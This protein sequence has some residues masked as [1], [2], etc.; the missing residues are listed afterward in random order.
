MKIQKLALLMLSVLTLVSAL[1][2]SGCAEEREPA[3]P[4]TI[5]DGLGRTIS[6]PYRPERL[7]CLTPSSAEIVFAVGA[8]KR[9]VAVSEYT[10]YPAEAQEIAKIGSYTSLNIEKIVA[11]KPDLLFADPYQELAVE[12]LEKLDLAVI[13][14]DYQNIELILI[15]IALVGKVLD[16]TLARALV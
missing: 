15:N 16:A 5:I 4:M 2:F 12:R 10:K 9:V 8:G 13:V 3:F 6:I 1:V 7:V 14:L 11:L